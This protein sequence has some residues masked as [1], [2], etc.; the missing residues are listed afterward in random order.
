M[1]QAG[2]LFG[3]RFLAETKPHRLE[4]FAPQEAFHLGMRQ[5]KL[6]YFQSVGFI[7]L[8]LHLVPQKSQILQMSGHNMLHLYDR[9]TCEPPGFWKLGERRVP[10]PN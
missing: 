6:C 1:A 4:D 2:A 9:G 5:Q 7:C 3:G 8:L 10:V